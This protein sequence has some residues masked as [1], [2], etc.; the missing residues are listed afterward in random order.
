MAR[1][2]NVQKAYV[3]EDKLRDYCL[4]N[5][6][7]I[8]KHKAKVFSNKL[9]IGK[10]DTA[11]LAKQIYEAIQHENALEQHEDQFG[12]RYAVDVP[13]KNENRKAT[14]RTAWIVKHHEN[15]PRLLTCYIKKTR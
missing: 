8:G 7:P 2:P 10:E 15:F 3:D 5:E 9:G 11:L 13:I 4:N 14:L 12:K 6:H 1:L